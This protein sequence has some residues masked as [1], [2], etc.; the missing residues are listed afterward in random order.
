MIGRDEKYKPFITKQN[1][2]IYGRAQPL[3][4]VCLMFY[5][6]PPYLSTCTSLYFLLP[7]VYEASSS[8]SHPPKCCAIF[9]RILLC[10]ERKQS[11]PAWETLSSPLGLE[12]VTWRIIL[13]A[14]SSTTKKREKQIQNTQ[15][16]REIERHET[17]S[18]LPSFF[19]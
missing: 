10:R 18:F 15:R 1:H 3:S 7:H 12:I 8:I 4:S 6:C 17:P 19:S 13:T 14:R 11:F 16:E 9:S 2:L 5:P